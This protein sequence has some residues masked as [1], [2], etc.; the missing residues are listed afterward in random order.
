MK[1]GFRITRSAEFPDKPYR[2][3]QHSVLSLHNTLDAH[4]RTRS[5]AMNFV[6]AILDDG[7]E[8]PKYRGPNGSGNALHIARGGEVKGAPKFFRR[9]HV[10]GFDFDHAQLESKQ[11]VRGSSSYRDLLRASIETK[12]AERSASLLARARM[13]QAH[14]R[15]AWQIAAEQNPSDPWAGGRAANAVLEGQITL[16]DVK[17]TNPRAS[18]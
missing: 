6:R 11:R 5:Q 1:A 4:F 13:L 7:E 2:V 18:I 10:Q 9:R 8:K 14:A 3:R 17:N 15:E 12:D 16:A